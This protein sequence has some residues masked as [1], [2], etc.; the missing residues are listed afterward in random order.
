[1]RRRLMCLNCNTP[2]RVLYVCDGKKWKRHSWGCIRCGNVEI[3]LIREFRP[4][5]K[6][7]PIWGAK[8]RLD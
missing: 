2:M 4:H 3:A 6:A 1:M 5:R 7:K 8:S